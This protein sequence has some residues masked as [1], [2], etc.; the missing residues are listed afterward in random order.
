M[1]PKF[2]EQ[3]VKFLSPVLFLEREELY[4]LIPY[5]ID[6]L[7]MMKYMALCENHANFRLSTSRPGRIET[8]NKEL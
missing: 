8:I 4:L 7:L 5:W 2:K 6:N 1:N 3:M